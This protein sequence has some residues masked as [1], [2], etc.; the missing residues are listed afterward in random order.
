MYSPVNVPLQT[1][2]PSVRSHVSNGS[3]SGLPNIHHSGYEHSEVTEFPNPATS[4]K[5]LIPLEPDFSQM[6]DPSVMMILLTLLTILR[7]DLH[8]RNSPEETINQKREEDIDR[9]LLLPLLDQ[10]L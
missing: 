3:I 9:L 10:P 5:Q 8:G 6:S 4:S 7:L 1:Y 2:A